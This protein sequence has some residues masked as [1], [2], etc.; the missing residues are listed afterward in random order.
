MPTTLT[1]AP[2]LNAP[3]VVP[4]PLEP[5]VALSVRP[6][7]QAL[8]DQIGALGAA[9]TSHLDWTDELIVRPG[10]TSTSFTIDV[11]AIAAVLLR[12][13]TG[14]RFVHSYV[15]GTI[16][17]SHV[18]GGDLGA[19][20]RFW[21]VYAYR[22]NGGALAFE[23]DVTS[24]NGARTHKAFSAT[25][26][27]LGCFAT[28]TTGAPLPMRAHRGRYTYRYSAL[29][30]TIRVLGTATPATAF[31]AVALAPF[32]PPYARLAHLR[33]SASSASTSALGQVHV[34]TPGDTSGY[35]DLNVGVS[36]GTNDAFASMHVEIETNATREIEYRRNNAAGYAALSNVSIT[37]LGWQE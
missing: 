15:G 18:A 1:P 37:V 17:A 7:Y 24:P 3:V 33:V 2:N 14:A 23:I 20:A 19:T 25:H 31:A 21:Y 29:G 30:T 13:G 4:N 16:G 34:R 6:G 36:D 22:D 10:G 35:F 9:L 28:D 12:D 27:Y 5:R 32:V 8:L 26:V 11:G